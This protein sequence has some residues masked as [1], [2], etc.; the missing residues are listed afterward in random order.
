[1]KNVS[2]VSGRLTKLLVIFVS[3]AFLVT[4]LSSCSTVANGIEHAH[5]EVQ[6][7]MSNTIFLNPVRPDQKT[8]F[9]EFRNTSQ[10]PMPD[11]KQMIIAK[12]EQKGYRIVADPYKAEFWL[13][14]NVLYMG[15]KKKHMT[16]AGMVAGGYGG[17]LTGLAFGRGY[18]KVG[19]VGAGT[20]IG[21]AVGAVVGAA[22]HVDTYIG[23]VDIQVKQKVNGTVQEQVTSNLQNGIG[24]K[25]KTNYKTSTQYQAFRTRIGVEATQTNLNLK[26][27][28]PVIEE[29][30]AQEIAGLFD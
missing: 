8:I 16:L 15:E 22:I 29:K 9:V 30:L 24:T 17:A 10:V 2:I 14:G 28:I 5:L 27:A 23:V 20:L 18:G 6:V 4:S 13:Q 25:I 12:L 3:L 11:L 19:A 26:K 7:K 1:M 21:S